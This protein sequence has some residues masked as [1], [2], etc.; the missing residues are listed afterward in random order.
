MPMGSGGGCFGQESTQTSHVGVNHGWC[1]LFWLLLS[2]SHFPCVSAVHGPCSL[3][4]GSRVWGLRMEASCLEGPKCLA[5]S[6]PSSFPNVFFSK[7][8][9]GVLFLRV[10]VGV[11]RFICVGFCSLVF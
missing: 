4:T 10:F 9:G 1:P 11:E 7:K 2:V 5:E 8:V 6:S 3:A